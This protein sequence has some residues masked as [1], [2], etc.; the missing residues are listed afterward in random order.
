MYTSSS[1]FVYL[2]FFSLLRCMLKVLRFACGSED[3]TQYN[4]ISYCVV[5]PCT[6]SHTTYWKIFHVILYRA[7][8]LDALDNSHPIEIPVGHPDEVDEIFDIISYSKGASVIRMLHDWIGDEVCS[9]LN[10]PA[11]A[12]S[13]HFSP[14]KRLGETR[15]LLD[16]ENIFEWFLVNISSWLSHYPVASEITD[17][18][19]V[20]RSIATLLLPASTWPGVRCFC[21][22]TRKRP[23][24]R[25]LTFGNCGKVRL[26]F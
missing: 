11:C 2:C 22:P 16:V 9:V 19:Y 12:G 8:D 15:R 24:H 20:A 4:T 10:A 7:L 18:V 26:P 3:V 5:E 17:I 1:S 6:D 21:L 14:Q 25:K 13:S 23:F